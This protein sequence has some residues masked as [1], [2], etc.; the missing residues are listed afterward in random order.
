[1]MRS[2]ADKVMWV[3]RATVFMVGL[4]VILALILGVASA[5]LG[6]NGKPLILGSAKNT[7]SKAT[8]MI[9]KVATGSA[10]TVKNPSGGSALGLQVNADQ[11]PLTVNPE[12]GTATNLSADELDGK[13]SAAYQRRVG[14]GCAEGSSIRTIDAE[15]RPT[16]EP[17][18]DRGLD[19][20]LALRTELGTNDGFVNGRSDPVSFSKVRNVPQDV[21][22]RNADTLDGRDSGD[23]A[24]T[25]HR[26]STTVRTN[27]ET[28]GG[29]IS[30][31]DTLSVQC[32]PGEVATGGGGGFTQ[33]A[34]QEML[35]IDE[36]TIQGQ[37]DRG[38]FFS[39]TTTIEDNSWA[40]G[41]MLGSYPMKVVDGNAV[42]A[43]DGEPAEAWGVSFIHERDTARDVK[44]WVVCQS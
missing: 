5:A 36:I 27:S 40:N 43:G 29:R 37:D 16:C 18:D 41:G 44:V 12:A 34:G 21:V 8:A 1:M 2:V 28:V 38:D 22:G 13:E 25:G 6:A 10:F 30:T 31:A 26:H 33:A 9:G 39:A 15:G 17:D 14:E 3:G 19:E 32:L 24:A 42:I 20:A 11:A 23:F 4:T 35:H 7:A